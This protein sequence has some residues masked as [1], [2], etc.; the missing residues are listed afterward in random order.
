MTSGLQTAIEN[1]ERL[2]EKL[3]KN[4]YGNVY[5]K[6]CEDNAVYTWLQR[7]KTCL[8]KPSIKIWEWEFEEELI[9][10]ILQEKA[11][12]KCIE[13]ICRGFADFEIELPYDKISEITTKKPVN[14]KTVDDLYNLYQEYW[15]K[16]FHAAFFARLKCFG[17][18]W[19]K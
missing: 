15:L 5:L 1:F 14:E 9:T 3:S 8:T 13:D 17:R 11:F 2:H 18:Y 6:Y 16:N 12:K 7:A 4:A 10:Y 19:N